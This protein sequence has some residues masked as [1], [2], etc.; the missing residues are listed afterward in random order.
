LPSNINRTVVENVETLDYIYQTT[1][2]A[3]KITVTLVGT[4]AGTRLA[5][6][7]ITQRTFTGSR[8][9]NYRSFRKANGYLPTRNSSDSLYILK[10][11]ERK[12]L[13]FNTL[14]DGSR[15]PTQM[16]IW[17][18]YLSCATPTTDFTPLLN[19]AWSKVRRKVL[20]QDFNAPV[21]IAEGKKTIDMIADRARSLAL[22][23]RSFR[24]GRL[25]D[26]AKH[27]GLTPKTAHNTWLEYKYGWSPLLSDIHGG[28]KTLAELNFKRDQRTFRAVVKRQETSK[29]TSP[30]QEGSTTFEA[31]A[32]V[33]VRSRNPSVQLQNRVGLLN[34]V[35]IAWELIPF[36]FVA[37]WFVNI[38]DCIS[39][40]TA[41]A[42]V[43]I[44]DGGS[45]TLTASTGKTF[46]T[47]GFPWDVWG[48][49]TYSLRVYNRTQGVQTMPRL[50]VKS[51]PLDLAKLVTSGAL[52]RQVTGHGGH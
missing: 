17:K 49:S 21:F 5:Q 9:S 7:Q 27:L 29:F 31:K 20:D 32:W 52:L 4:R 12:Q 15:R 22:A 8:T 48:D 1:G 41:F 25:A 30:P 23:Y 35:L 34:P 43:Q 37:D 47:N 10:G 36:S 38:G 46:Q 16:R 2:T 24:K 26:V 45:S 50:R 40:A 13:T 44:L 11:N 18:D 28:A 39:E 6:S 42:G 51:N 3:P 33:T 19:E 14:A